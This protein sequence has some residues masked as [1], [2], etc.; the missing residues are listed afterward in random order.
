M[1][2][3]RVWPGASWDQLQDVATA[4]FSPTGL[5]RVAAAARPL[6]TTALMVVAG[7]QVVLQ[8]G[9]V[10]EITYQASVRKSLLSLLYGTHVAA[11]RIRLD[12]TLAALDIDDVEGLRPDERSATVADLLTARSGVY[13]PAANPG[14]D[15]QNAPPR[16]SRAPGTHFL[17][18]NWD[19]NVL[20]TIFRAA[21][22]Y[23]RVRRGVHRSR[24]AAGHAGL[25]AESATDARR[26]RAV[27]APRVPL[28]PLVP[29]SRTRRT[30]GAAGR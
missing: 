30:A 11:G 25:H 7:G 21:D 10:A 28:L 26:A 27:P 18:N 2:V 24:P 6:A 14:G 23:R 5:E 3:D 9:D 29:R 17:Y 13:H 1:S 8:C 20:G 16:G 15:E 4:G 19:F 22:P 12:S